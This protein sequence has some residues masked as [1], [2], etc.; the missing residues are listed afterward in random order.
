MLDIV[1]VGRQIMFFSSKNFTSNSLWTGILSNFGNKKILFGN[2][3]KFFGY[4]Y[5]ILWCKAMAKLSFVD[6]SDMQEKMY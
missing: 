5:V 3:V 4:I 2:Y 1:K 6:F